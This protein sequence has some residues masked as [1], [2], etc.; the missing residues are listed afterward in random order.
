ML[1][2]LH[3]LSAFLFYVLGSVLFLSYV[4]LHNGIGGMTP[5]NILLYADLPMAFAATLYG[6]LSV[7][8]SIDE[9]AKGSTVLLW[10]V[11]LPLAVLFLVFVVLNFW[12]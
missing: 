1:R 11:G 8:L 10:S 5:L 12:N 9:E 3:T 4:L 2:Y 7:Y 6:G